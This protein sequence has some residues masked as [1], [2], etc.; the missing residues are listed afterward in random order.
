MTL[1]ARLWRNPLFGLVLRL[2][3]IVLV[4][5]GIWKLLEL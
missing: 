5:L 1:L 3:L 4:V 2:W